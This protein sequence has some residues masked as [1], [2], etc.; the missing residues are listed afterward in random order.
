MQTFFSDDLSE[1][2]QIKG[3]TSRQ[4]KEGEYFMILS[5]ED[6]EEEYHLPKADIMKQA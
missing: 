1:E 4:S 2:I 5:A 3:R 6:I